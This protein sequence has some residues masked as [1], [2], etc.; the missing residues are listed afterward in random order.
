MTRHVSP[1]NQTSVPVLDQDGQPLAPTRPSR[2][3]RWLESG[4]AVKVWKK[5]KFA[6][7]LT[8]LQAE[9]CVIP[10]AQPPASTQHHHPEAEER[11][12]RCQR[13]TRT[14]PKPA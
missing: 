6:V 12:E 9:N 13:G 10:P 5:G 1:F 7:R 11:P 14:R 3:R 8:D 4:R 2:A